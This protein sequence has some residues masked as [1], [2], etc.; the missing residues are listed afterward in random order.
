[1]HSFNKTLLREWREHGLH[2]KEFT[3]CST[4]KAKVQKFTVLLSQT[5][6]IH[7]M[8]ESMGFT[9]KVGRKSGK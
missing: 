6:E 3:V 2:L 8:G 7:A 5:L 9:P 1:M 4:N